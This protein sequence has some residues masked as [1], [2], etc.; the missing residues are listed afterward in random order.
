MEMF[1]LYLIYIKSKTTCLSW[2]KTKQMYNTPY[3]KV[4]KLNNLKGGKNMLYIG[5]FI[6]DEY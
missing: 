3:N 5:H 1:I 6:R 2:Q 4:L